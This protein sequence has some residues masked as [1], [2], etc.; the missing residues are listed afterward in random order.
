MKA[1]QEC[2]GIFFNKYKN[3]IQDTGQRLG[4]S[5]SRQGKEQ[6]MKINSTTWRDC[7]VIS[8]WETP[9]KF[10]MT[11]CLLMLMH[12]I[13]RLRYIL[14]LFYHYLFLI[15]PSFGASAMLC[16]VIVVFQGI[17]TYIV[18]IEVV[19][20]IGRSKAVVPVLV[21]LFVAC[22]LFYEAICC[23]SFRVSFCSCVF[24]SF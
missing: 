15:S 17:F 21:L 22:S 1:S 19:C 5:E 6:N 8:T 24:Q 12:Y 2:S 18:R 3:E 13:L 14:C 11:S 7:C 16:F 9:L 23:M 20:S 4:L 10:Q